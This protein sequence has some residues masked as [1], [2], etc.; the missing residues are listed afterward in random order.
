MRSK[1]DFMEMRGEPSREEA[2]MM[3][4]MDESIDPR[5]DVTHAG[6]DFFYCL[7][8][9]DLVRHHK[10]LALEF[11]TGPSYEVF[12]ERLQQLYI[13]TPEQW[14]EVLAAWAEKEDILTT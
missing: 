14:E 3:R 10:D 5:E 12:A 13:L 4:Q 9:H 2:A 8:W 1:E 11:L 6:T 7:I